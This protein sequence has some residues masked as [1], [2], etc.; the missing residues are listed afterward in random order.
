MDS[1]YYTRWISSHGHKDPGLFKASFLI[2]S[3]VTQLQPK[4]D[5]DPK[6]WPG[7]DHDWRVSLKG[8]R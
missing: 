2:C 5:S 4:P 7:L 8:E 6:G 1:R 3:W